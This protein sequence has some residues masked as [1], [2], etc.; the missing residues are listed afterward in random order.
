MLQYSIFVNIFPL[1][2]IC[3][4][5]SLLDIVIFNYKYI[6]SQTKHSPQVH[7]LTMKNFVWFFSYVFIGSEGRC[8][9]TVWVV[10]QPP[11]FKIFPDYS[12]GGYYL[13]T[14][15]YLA[16]TDSRAWCCHG[17][18]DDAMINYFE[19]F[20]SSMFHLYPIRKTHGKKWS[21]I[22]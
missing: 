17:D 19:N 18:F 10:M 15:V 4:L 3:W 2:I 21:F 13:L 22:L 20:T 6:E 9:L 16:S 12:S 5:Y 8:I 1:L 7:M 11:Q 14:A